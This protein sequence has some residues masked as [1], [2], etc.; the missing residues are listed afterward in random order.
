MPQKYAQDIN[1]QGDHQ[2]II[3]MYPTFVAH[4]SNVES[5]EPGDLVWVDYGNKE[6]FEDPTYIG[7][8]FPPPET[9]GAGGAGGGGASGSAAFGNCG[10]GAGLSGSSGGSVTPNKIPI[11]MS[12]AKWKNAMYLTASE[13]KKRNKQDPVG[14]TKSW[15]T[16]ASNFDKV[17]S[18]VEAGG[19]GRAV[20][21]KM[22][23][24]S[25]ESISN[26]LAKNT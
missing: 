20:S 6:N 22:G 13:T 3:N 4:D 16:S 1:E 25:C 18:Y 5:A 19:S 14:T 9:S 26:N 15:S 11:T 8:V 21:G 24:G 7:P 17:R 23:L 12:D 10:G 2:K